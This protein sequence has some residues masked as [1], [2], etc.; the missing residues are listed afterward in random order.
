M[1]LLRPWLLLC[2]EILEQW[3]HDLL[4]AAV[5]SRICLICVLKY[6]ISSEEG[7]L[8]APCCSTRA[9]RS[10]PEAG[11]VAPS[12]DSSASPR[13]EG[14]RSRARG[15]QAA[16]R[17]CVRVQGKEAGGVGGRGIRLGSARSRWAARLQDPRR[18]RL[19]E[20]QRALRVPA[21]PRSSRVGLEQAERRGLAG[22]PLGTGHVA[23]PLFRGHR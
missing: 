14:R 17:E 13:E 2:V 4:Q 8:F 21:G 5:T 10:P 22:R 15:G 18:R 16:E 3:L 11:A 7:R 20:E 19:P 6:R 23:C 9:Q 12:R 1:L